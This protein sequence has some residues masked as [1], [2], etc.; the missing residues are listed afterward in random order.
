MREVDQISYSNPPQAPPPPAVS[1]AKANRKRALS[2]V[3]DG[4]GENLKR[5]RL[6]EDEGREVQERTGFTEQN[7]EFH[8][9]VPRVMGS[10]GAVGVVEDGHMGDKPSGGERWTWRCL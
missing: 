2:E 4:V 8:A 1:V 10:D 3:A 9:C 6:E 7:G 5:W